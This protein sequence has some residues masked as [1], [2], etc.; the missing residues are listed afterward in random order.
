MVESE[1]AKQPFSEGSEH[2]RSAEAPE[3]DNAHGKHIGEF[4]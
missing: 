3:Q 2:P 4:G 1:H